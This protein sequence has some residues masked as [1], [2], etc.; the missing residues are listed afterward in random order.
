MGNQ[1]D[2]HSTENYTIGKGILYVAEWNGD[3]PP[4]W[5]DDY[6][7]MGNCSSIEVEP[8]TERLPHYSS[9]TSFRLKDKNPVMQRDYMVSFDADEIAAANLN[10]FLMG[11]LSGTT[12]YALQR[13]N[14]EYALRFVS[15][16]PI[17]PN[18]TWDFWR[19]TLNPN[20]ALQL[21]GEEWMAMSFQGEGLADIDN[22]SASPY[23]TVDYSSSSSSS[24][25]SS[26]SS[27][28]SSLSSSSSSSS[29]SS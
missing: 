23:F 3:T 16:N 24:S 20:G 25:S 7:D 5:P 13:T 17:G 27:S 1:Q 8:T 22:H 9:R 19:C 18:E 6:D 21:I 29:S 15:D 12:I 26:L 14:M 4:T 11:T 2:P 10:R 28:S